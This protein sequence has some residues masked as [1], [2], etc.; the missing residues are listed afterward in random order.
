MRKVLILGRE[1]ERYYPLAK[2]LTDA[3]TKVEVSE[4]NELDF[5]I[6][7]E[8]THIICRATGE[9]LRRYAKILVL[10]V[11]RNP[12]QNH[13]LNAVT[14]YCRK[15]NIE[16]LDD[17]FPNMNGKLVEMWKFWENGI[18]IPKTA[19][20][21]VEFLVSMLPKFGGVC[22]LKSI[23]GTQGK[24]NYLVKSADEIRNLVAANPE[25]EFI[26]QNFIPNV[27]DYRIV[28]INFEPKLAIYRSANGKNFRNN[29]SLGSKASLV[30]LEE[31][32]PTVLSLAATAARALNIK[33]A[34]ADILQNKE[35]GEYSVLEVNRAPQLATGVFIEA[36]E[37]VLKELAG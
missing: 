26:L 35:T 24:D 18:A 12:E 7:D 4:Y 10:S 22:V 27:G 30:S 19:F 25:T 16:I 36:K 28:V 1:K 8:K 11:S 31:L 33:I 14:C 23:K 15:Y 37:T 20:G 2:N 32:D 34:G 17:T 6:D 3:Q 21:S 5:L 9:D 13:I 29:T